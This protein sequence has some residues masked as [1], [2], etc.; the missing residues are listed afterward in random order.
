V[1]TGTHD[2][3]WASTLAEFTA[4]AIGSGAAEATAQV[5]R[6]R[7]LR[8]AEELGVHPL[9]VEESRVA[10]Y[11][12]SLPARYASPA[13][14]KAQR[15]AVVAFYRWA[16]VTGRRLDNPARVDRARLQ[17]SEAWGSAIQ[18][19]GVDQRA[20]GLAPATIAQRAK[21]LRKF[22]SGAVVPPWSTTH[23]QVHR[24]LL[25]L[26]ITDASR[27]AHRSALRAF[28]R[29]A[30]ATARVFADPMA[31]S[32]SGPTALPVPFAW[33]AV[34]VEYRS[35]LRA[36]A[37]AE[38]SIATFLETLR[39]FA[40]QTAHL[41]PF[42]V[43]TDDVASWMGNKRWAR[44][45]RRRNRQ[46]LLGFYRWAALTGRVESNPVEA[47]PIVKAEQPHPR[48]AEDAE[49]HEALSRAEDRERLALRLAAELGMRRGEVARVHTRDVQ[50]VAGNRELVVLGK[51]GKIRRLPVPE[52]LA[53]LILSR[54]PGFAFPGGDA[55]H[56]SARWLGRRVTRLLPDG[57]TMHQL[58][59]R[60]ATRAYA[61]DRD[62][63]GVQELLGHA[64]PATTRGYV[65]LSQASLR[66]LVE[67]VAS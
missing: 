12:E 2:D 52:G 21:Y 65:R 31:Y 46:T 67:G 39:H 45:T 22:A 25:Q 16:R 10:G 28:Y 66:R 19:F 37:R 64:S 13:S 61:I 44:E 15:L 14:A 53:L 47:L 33:E 56:L 20:L 17:V 27:A 50:G 49:Y 34:L 9:H 1:R 40:R 55:G 29:W 7:L 51:G 8:L 41:A 5:R 30:A 36:G 6:R 60:F 24:W 59:H 54:G 38:T 57:V 26:E 43:T 62:L 35:Y 4:D 11:L 32:F 3:G 42:E 58:R 48:P 18:Q 63:F 23:E